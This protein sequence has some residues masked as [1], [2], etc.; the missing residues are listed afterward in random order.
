MKIKLDYNSWGKF[1]LDNKRQ[2]S[3]ANVDSHQR[4]DGIVALGRACHPALGVTL[5]NPAPET[6]P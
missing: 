6:G 4:D 3:F 2:N 5:P 1:G